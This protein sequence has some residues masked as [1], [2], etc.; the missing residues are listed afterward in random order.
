MLSA[1]PQS[2]AA[3][4]GLPAAGHMASAVPAVTLQPLCELTMAVWGHGSS[5]GFASFHRV[6]V[7][8]SLQVPC[9]LAF[10]L[11]REIVLCAI[12]LP[13]GESPGTGLVRQ[14]ELLATLDPSGHVV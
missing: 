8:P 6:K 9:M 11:R 7:K 4:P 12:D 13:V 10:V 5:V 3:G 2:T 14:Q 1:V